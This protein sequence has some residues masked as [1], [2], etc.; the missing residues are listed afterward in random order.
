MNTS[1]A[2]K[3]STPSYVQSLV[4]ISLLL[5]FAG[6]ISAQSTTAGTTPLGTA[7]GA[8]TG[9]Y[10][11]SGFDNINLFNANLNFRLPVSGA[12]GRGGAHYQMMLPIEQKWIVE[13]DDLDIPGPPSS[14]TV[15]YASSDWWT[16]IRPGYGPGVL[17]G[18][19]GGTGS[20][21]CSIYTTYHYNKTLTRLTFIAPDGTEFELRDQLTGGQP[22]DVPQC[23]SVG[24]SRGTVF[25]TADG[26]AATFIS[27]SNVFD[28][29]NSPGGS[30][31]S[32]YLMTRDGTRYRIDGGLV[33]WLRDR[34]GNKL[35]FTYDTYSRVTTVTDSLNRQVTIAY[36][37]NDVAPYGLCD[38]ITYKGFG[39]V[40]RIVRVSKTAMGNVLRAGY[41]LQTDL[42]LFPELRGSS[43]TPFNPTVVSAV[44]L[45]DD[46]NSLRYQF[47]YNSYGEL[48]RVVLPTGGGIEYDYAAGLTDGAA[49][50]YLTAGGFF[51]KYIYRRV[52][53][54]RVYKDGTTLESK[55]T[56]SRPESGVPPAS[57]VNL[58]Y[59]TV[60]Q[61]DANGALLG[62]QNHYFY[63]SARASFNPGGGN[64]A[65]ISYPAWQDGREY[66]T[67]T[68]DTDGVTMLRRATN[69]W[70]QRAPVSWW[71]G[72]PDTAPPNDPR[73]N[74]TDATLEPLGANL[75][76]KRTFSYDNSVP[77]NNQSD[78]Y[79]YDFGVG[80]PGALMRRTH[81][82]YLTSSSYTGTDVHLRSLPVQTSIYDA[83]GIERARASFEYDNYTPDT[84]H[85][86]LLDRFGISSFDSSFTTSYATRGNATATTHYLL[87]SSGSVIGSISAYAQYDIAGNVVKAI[88]ARG[89]ATNLEYAD[90]FGA[91][92]GD[93]QSNVAPPELGGLTSYA[94]AT[95][96]TN[97]QGHIAFAQFDYYL[98]RP[99]DGQDANGVVASGYYSD[100]LDRPTQ[101]RRAVG[102]SA[103][104]QTSFS[105]DDTNR[106]ITTT[107]DLNNN[108]DNGLVGKALYDN[109]GRTIE[110]RQYEG[111]TNYI[112]AQVQYDALGR[113]FKTS[114]PF[115]PWN[116]ESPIWTTTAFDA[117]GRVTSVTTPDN[118][119]ASSSYTGNT[120]TVTDQAGKARK[121]VADALG[122]LSTVYEDPSGVNYST[123]YSYDAL[124]NLIT[125]SQ[126]AQTRTFVYDS[127]K[128]L[129]S[130]T[131][132]ESGTVSCD[133]DN[134]GNLLRKTDARNITTTFVFDALNRPTSKSYNDNPQ[135]PPV[136]YFYDSQTLPA[137]APSFDRGYATG[138]LV[139]VT[140]GS[141][142]SAGTYRGYDAMGRVIRQYQ[143]T[144]AVNYLVEATYNLAG[145]VVTETYPS[146][147]GAGDRR[148]VSFSYDNAAR[149]SSLSSAATSYAPAASVSSI[150]Y[151][152]H[153]GLNTETYGNSL[154]H[155]I[156]YNNRLQANEIKLGTS[157]NP[158]SVLDLTYN[159][160][161]TNNNGNVQSISYSGGGLSYTQTFGYDQLNRLTTSQENSGSSWSETNGYDQYG[162]RW[163]DYGGGNHNLSFSTSTNR[164]TTSGYSYDAVGNLLNDTLHNYTFD[165]ENKI[166]NVDGVAAYGYD[167]GG[168]RVRKLVG[169][170][171]R[172]V[173]GIGGELVAEFDGATGNVKKEYI[174]GGATLATIEPTAVN[175]NGTQYTTSDHLGSPRVITNSSGSVVGRHDYMPFGVE[176]GAGVGGRTTAMGFSNTGDNNRKKFTGK[177]R[178]NETGLDFFEA[179]YYASMQG[180]FTSSDPVALT[181]ERLV[182][183]QRINLY[184]YCRNNPLAFI[185]PTGEIVTFANDDARKKYEEYVKFLNGD[186]KKYANELATVNRLQNSEVEY[187]LSVGGRNF[188]GAEGN[189]TTDGQRI[190]VAISNVG[191]SSG[192]TFSLNSRFSHELEHARQFDNGELT[193]YKGADGKWH[194]SP[195]TYDIG[196]EVKAWKA[197]LNTSTASDF[198]K[199]EGGQRKP[200]LLRE[201]AN[202]KT[203]DERAGVLARTSGYRNRNP[204]QNSDFVYGGKENYKPGQLIRTND[205]F[206]RVNRV[207]QG[208][209]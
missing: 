13:Q 121:S 75:V 147:P 109:L 154:V 45:W 194:P 14:Q 6:S 195:T 61:L 10:A 50:G 11:L 29:V 173:Y 126:G 199:T 35:S 89:Y 60:D 103:A 181:V 4:L 133:Y 49:S 134:N 156:T 146:V 86:A 145:G 188:E 84:N 100:P 130:A 164:I 56:Y 192:E 71:T 132:P 179:R 176:L 57:P 83:G 40:N 197:Q 209:K 193:F 166:K 37:V 99:V 28:S 7:P 204:N 183:P 107:S 82:D 124:D 118:A 88:D 186:K 73:V 69:V 138:R 119:V 18:R 185:D 105:Y 91:P 67:D 113:A 38:K 47:F 58:G 157:G 125:V 8:P 141:S 80:V 94:F 144:D 65:P 169:E 59:V 23:P 139:A 68:L 149:V 148:T 161:A 66:Q 182:D 200:S 196:D 110:T 17:E 137:G 122:R 70:E 101:V 81:T 205:F 97:A 167:A 30:P 79:E 24:F 3:T 184:A 16:G 114:N 170:N 22:Q 87:N 39:G 160:G 32:G 108:N 95:K 2:R 174:Y 190:N 98:G 42:Q 135:T 112:A 175:A 106:I 117:L 19:T 62:R 111:G 77:Y 152:S 93:A 64:Q 150:G 46:P 36:D 127:L 74:E 55:M 26:T 171:T 90:R 21:Q 51:H 20:S 162:N 48:A 63:G 168:Q 31:L 72:T 142:S 189:T 33:T 129:T 191:G 15:W 92:D 12:G 165:A 203:D 41:T 76:S 201:F 34:N 116:L 207:A 104:S 151:A 120:V 198:W 102:T 115:R 85:A 206:G 54:R 123:S 52:I 155:A 53:E 140:Y 143:Q 96:V 43:R 27:D 9:S 172:F 177:E 128:R 136:N 5:I 44:W 131:N 163:I 153:N 178:D 208:P 187:R 25:T 78:V 202:A 158:T 159:Y 1:F 180:R